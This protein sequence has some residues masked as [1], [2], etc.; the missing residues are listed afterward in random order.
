MHVRN[1]WKRQIYTL[2][3]REEEGE[4]EKERNRQKKGVLEQSNK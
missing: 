3:E 2:A 4:R 1:D